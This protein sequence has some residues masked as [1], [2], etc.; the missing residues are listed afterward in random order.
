MFAGVYCFDVV[1][2]SIRP[3]HIKSLNEI[4]LYYCIYLAIRW[5][6]PSLEWLQITKSVIWNFAVIQILPFLN[7]PKDLDPSYKMDLDFWDYLEVK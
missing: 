3:Q 1:L 6:F 2:L 7:D 4:H 5:G